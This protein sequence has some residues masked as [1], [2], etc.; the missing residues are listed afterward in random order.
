[1]TA[2]AEFQ[3]R[4]RRAAEEA[5]RLSDA[6]DANPFSLRLRGELRQITKGIDSLDRQIDMARA[7]GG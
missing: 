3:A 6:V 4:R 1:M 5:T 2:L 7:R